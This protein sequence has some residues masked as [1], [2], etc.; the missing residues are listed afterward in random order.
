MRLLQT[1]F[2][3]LRIAAQGRGSWLVIALLLGMLSVVPN[4]ARAGTCTT[5]S[6]TV[7]SGNQ[8]V[9]DT[10]SCTDGLG[11]DSIQTN[12]S[13]GTLSVSA[14]LIDITYTND[15]KGATS[16]S[17]VYLD[18]NN[19]PV[20]VN[21]TIGT[22]STTPVTVSPASAPNGTIG[23]AY[24]L[25]FSASGGNGGP[26]T[27]Q[28][29]QGVLPAGL[30]DNSSGLISGTPTESGAFTFTIAA[31]DSAN[32]TGE[33]TI[34]LTITGGAISVSPAS[35]NL[36]N[37][38]AYQS[39][40]QTLSASGGTAPYTYA[41]VPGTAPPA[42]ISIGSSGAISG[43]STT[44]GSTNFSVQ[45]TDST[46]VST[47]VSYT[48]QVVAPTITVTPSTV[49][50][51]IQNNA[52]TAQTLT[53]SGGTSPYT[54]AIASG[55]LPGGMTL[56]SSGVLSGTP[57][58]T[59]SFPF[60]AQ[61]TDAHGFTGS[62]N[63]TL[64]VNAITV[65]G[66]PTIGTATAGNAQA[67]VTF[68]APSNN[69]GA[70]ITGY[71]ATSSPGGL[72]GSCATSPCT[73]TGLTNGTAYTFTVTA[74]NS[75]GTSTA[76]AASNS[77]TPRASQTIT[78]SNPGTQNFGTT[79]TLTA[80]A[81]SGLTVSF[82]STTTAVCT[83]TSTGQL[84]FITAGTCSI[85]ADQGG[86]GAYSPAPTVSQ[87]FSV[88]AVVPG[89]PTIGTATPGNTQASVSFTAPPFTG[90]SPIT[91][92]TVTSSPGGL[93]GTCATSPCVVTGL[94]DGTSYTFTV[95]ATNSAGT[96]AA[97]A[98]SNSVTPASPQ[99]I[100]FANPGTQ[101]FG[102]TP[103]LTATTTSG[104]TVSFS[105]STTAVCTITSGGALTTVSAG[106]CTINANQAGNSA[107]LPAA[108]V[109]QSFAIMPVLPG[110]PVIGTATAGNAQASVN[111][112]PPTFTG[113][114]SITSYTAT[115]SPGGLTGTCAASPCVVT[116]LVNGTA[117]TFTVTA[118]NSAGTGA[119]S[120]ASNAVT[121]KN[122]QTIT[123]SNPGT[124]NFGATPTLT[125]TASSGL[126]VSF[127]SSTTAVCT[128]TSGGALTTVSPGSCVIN[129]NQAGNGAYSPAP[130]VS[131][132]F[133][134][135]GVAPG[136]PIIGTATA[137][138]AQA[139]VTFTPPTS[140][141][142]NP[143]TGYTA[144]SSPGGVTST[145]AASPCTITTLTNGTAYT[146]TVTATNAAGTGAA[147]AASNSVTPKAVGA[148]TNFVANP[149]QPVFKPSGTFTVS[150][151][152]DGSSSP[153]V[154]A[155]ASSSNAVCSIQSS[156]VTTLSAGLCSITA[157]QAGDASHLAAPQVTLAVTI[158]NPPAPVASNVSATTNYNTAT[159]INL[160]SA[161]AGIDVTSVA[162]AKA[163]THGTA[164]VSGES[165]TYTPASAFYGGTDSFTYTASNP[166]GASSPATVTVT[167]APSA[168]P[169]AAAHAVATTA[170]TPVTVQAE[171]GATGPQPFVGV[172]VATQPAH[173]NAVV[174]GDQITY[175]PASGYTGTDTFTY[176]VSNHFGA[177]QPA[178]IS[179]TVTAAGSASGH[180]KTVMTTPGTPV[181]VNL[182]SIVPG[183]YTSSILEGLSPASAGNVS[184]SQPTALTFTP[185][186]NFL[187]L[188]QITAVLTSSTGDLVTVDVLV[189]VS[190]Q[191]DPS[192][193]ADVLGII[194]AQTTE[195]QL[196]A[197][198][199]LDNIRG[200]LESLHDGGGSLFSN[201][202]SISLDGRP[203]HSTGLG[204]TTNQ[205]WTTTGMARPG[206]GS[207][208]AMGD[209]SMS[210]LA[211]LS[212][213]TSDAR[214]ST[215]A[216]GPQGLGVWIGGAANFG[217]FDAYRQ[218]AGFD[219]DN[220]AVTM[221][222]D[223]RIGERGVAGLSLG[224]N[225]DNSDISNDGTHS[226]AEGFSAALYGS[227]Q[228]SLRTYI[229]G[230]L[231]GG[232][233]SFS[234]RRFDDNNGTYLMGHRNGDQWYASLTGG[235]EYKWGSWLLSPYGRLEWSLS[236]LNSY[237]ETGDVIDALT[238]GNQLVRT[239]QTILGVRAS[240]QIQ[241][242]FGT[243]IPHVRFEFGHDFQGTGNTS[244]SYAFIPS[245][246][247][248]S[249]ITNPYSANGNSAQIGFGSDLQLQGDWLITTEYDYLAQPHAHDQ[250]I[251]FGVKKQF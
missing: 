177:S 73:V 223:Q 139:T 40:N 110:A 168:V 185:V 248:W 141:G 49:P 194:N 213:T 132:T 93:T 34:T 130:Q 70:A 176:A 92:Y 179:V 119:P 212:P 199:Q 127:S 226:I 35:G 24:S 101:N 133:A 214:S 251:R 27:Y 242:S 89:P 46:G 218:A 91:A 19:R 196:F 128:I 144:I 250:M 7:A 13:H 243:L 124:Q 247:S 205:P 129:A 47:Q 66:A 76:S 117:Y 246:G 103:T 125:A 115:S 131:Q 145:C 240:G 162:I 64:T 202:L 59:G 219:S 10:S 88:A 33:V 249:V 204:T 153:V 41:Q 159:T 3:W 52:Y 25:Q 149:A 231:G 95:T 138:D 245:A 105:S 106:T 15:G 116:G 38:I 16:D 171:S 160:T 233:L 118:T 44:L 97:S 72:T 50:S 82:S 221:G 120:A 99:T 193:N 32:N 175:T 166:G 57:T 74:T 112:V 143:I 67:S 206:I 42:G 85:N 79:P 30:S 86:N 102:T 187:G 31:T 235:Y 48:L 201:T 236:R 197:Q 137:G 188:V 134:I 189:V 29:N 146:F 77:V 181:T 58:V 14:N 22:S 238:Y 195:A 198:S 142:G 126:T 75:V 121:P 136:A 123:F 140:N 183:S 94:T 84:T 173:G 111:F 244:L 186:G 81:S 239:S 209:A 12:P 227:F 109:S 148:I 156:T 152:G 37:A 6:F 211:P 5:Q 228:P 200:R 151:T 147:S 190:K 241:E 96:G 55:A 23:Q 107:Y 90:G 135:A 51:A 207:S 150:A 11:I 61:A 225:H 215:P 78:F 1:V 69:G 65:P 9:L 217:S 43:T 192:K 26:Y 178:T 18:D 54:F 114:A 45:V 2:A 28:I 56:T 229:D 98:A 169:V 17:Y 122:N 100:T 210:P 157:N 60:S 154:F 182:G 164:T 20:T 80:A 220:L 234:S 39:Y 21:I 71:T 208:D 4:I 104:L 222:V 224:Y 203:M 63:Y 230:V 167:V 170:G 62:Q 155:I 180:T 191:P 87:S 237:S 36:P 113:G 53:A 232:G 163:P 172:S 174:S 108:Q 161:I 8:Y 165:V 68:T 83:I 184:L 216:K 158:N